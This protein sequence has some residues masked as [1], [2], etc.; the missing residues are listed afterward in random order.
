MSQKSK[1]ENV[2]ANVQVVQRQGTNSCRRLDFSV[3]KYNYKRPEY[4]TQNI[5]LQHKSHLEKQQTREKFGWFL[6]EQRY[7]LTNIDAGDTYI[8]ERLQYSE[9]LYLIFSLMKPVEVICFTACPKCTSYD[10]IETKP[11]FLNINISWLH[12]SSLVLFN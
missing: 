6:R 1:K 12:K 3:P 4:A 8:R 2:S 11:T 9:H 10:L 7:S 5:P